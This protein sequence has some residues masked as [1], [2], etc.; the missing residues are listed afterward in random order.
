M[1]DPYVTL[2]LTLAATEDDIRAAYR[3]RAAEIHPD[4]QPAHRKDWAAEQ[5][6]HL[7]AARDFLLDPPRRAEYDA[8][9]RAASVE[10]RMHAWAEAREQRLRMRRAQQAWLRAGWGVAAASLCALAILAPSVMLGLGRFILGALNIIAVVGAAV[11]APVAIA[12][13]LGLIVLS[14]RNL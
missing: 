11:L 12:L 1:V 6:R 5:M 10:A 3:R 7:N 9:L 8:R 4:T 14:F 13:V 2:N